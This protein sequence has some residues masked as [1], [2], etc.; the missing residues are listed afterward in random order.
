MKSL[1]GWV[2][3]DLAPRGAV[4]ELAFL[5]A[6]LVNPERASERI[7]GAYKYPVNVFESIFNN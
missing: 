7:V 5:A 2:A 1:L 6:L 3:I 4:V